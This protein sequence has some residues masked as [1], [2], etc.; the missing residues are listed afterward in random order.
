M[1]DLENEIEEEELMDLQILE[2][3]K[4]RIKKDIKYLQVDSIYKIRR[5]FS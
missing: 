4:K 5:I 1:S 2:N 3:E